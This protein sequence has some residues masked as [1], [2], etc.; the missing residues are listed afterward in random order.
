MAPELVR[1]GAYFGPPV[2][3]W[4]LGVFLY[5][6]LH[7]RPPFRAQT[8]QDLNVRIM[9]CSFDAFAKHISKASQN[10]MR[11]CMSVEV[12]ERL[13]AKDAERLAGEIAERALARAEA[14]SAAVP[15][16]VTEQLDHA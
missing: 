9:K 3:C 4:A 10:F 13:H 1:G 16:A 2:D 5:E 11:R 15:L 8:M 7:N 6:L 14:A 12:S